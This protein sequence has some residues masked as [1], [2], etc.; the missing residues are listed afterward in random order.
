VFSLDYYDID[1]QGYIDEFSPQEIL[2]GCYVLG[3]AASCAN[4]R[5]VGGGL[6]LDGSGVEAFTTNLN[7]IQAEGVE[8]GFTLGFDIGRFGQLTFNGN[9]NKYLT[10]EFQ[11][12]ATSPVTDCNG[13][14][15]T[16]CGGPLPEVRWLQ[17]TSWD[18]NNFQVSLIWRHLGKVEREIPDLEGIRAGGDE[19]F[20]PFTKIDAHDY[21]DLYGSWQVHDVAKL[22]AG[23]TNLF[24]KDPPVLGN[25][26]ADTASNSGN[27]F[28]SAY[29]PLG[30]VFSLGVNFAF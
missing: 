28:P 9:V 16:S 26:A 27:T 25:E 17:R 30:R 18:Y 3:N 29:D 1:I 13:Y 5:R 8:L 14:F 11:S 22:Y 24:D 21:F 23:V 6:T 4:I 20:A 12:A 19:P 15:G 10:Q 7:Y 2:D